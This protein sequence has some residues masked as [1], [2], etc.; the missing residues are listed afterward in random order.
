ME[1]LIARSGT[2]EW[3]KA[4]EYGVSA[5]TVAKAAAGP[6][7]YD[8]E[9]KRALHPEDHV[10]E[11]NAYMKFGRDW[12]QWIVDNIPTE[13]GI[14]HNDWLIRAEEEE[15]H[16][17]T[18][19]GLNADWTM[20]AEVK[21]TGVDWSEGLE[22]D[23]ILALSPVK[24]PIQY[25]RQVQWQMYVTGASQCV[26][27]WLL[28]AGDYPEFLPAWLEPKYIFINRDDFMIDELVTVAKRFARDFNHYKEA[29]QLFRP[30]H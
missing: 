25:R 12:E 14:K 26:F 23:A 30:T 7:G 20:I 6:G 18:P 8:A 27:A 5:T 10:I 29:E 1:R 9:L 3:Y 11:D 16:L 17:A 21:T 24:I 13:L 4:R 19:D 2:D 22:P 15:H 28:R